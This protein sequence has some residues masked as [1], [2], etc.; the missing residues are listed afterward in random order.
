MRPIYLRPLT[1]AE[2]TDLDRL[3]RTARSP[4]LRIRVQA[5]LL[6]A[7]RGWHA[8]QIAPIVR[9]NPASVLRWIKRFN[10]EGTRGL[11]D[12]PRPGKPKKASRAYRERLEEI[13]RQRPRSLGLEFSLWTLRRLAD[14]MAEETGER[15]SYESVR[16]YLKAA[17][18]VF[19]RP[20]HT[21]TSPDPEYLL[22]KRRSRRSETPCRSKAS[23]TTPTRRT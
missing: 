22:K 3:Y 23:S 2:H 5:I 7:E 8:G 14:F 1:E 9:M 20:Q 21:I 10:A 4:R 18:I 16:R 17:G 15:V 19:R 11:E 12:A 6:A 13:V